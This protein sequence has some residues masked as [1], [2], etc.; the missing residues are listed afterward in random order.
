MAP[1]VEVVEIPF[2]KLVDPTADLTQEIIKVRMLYAG[3]CSGP[4]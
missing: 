4:D 3:P 1:K 2:A